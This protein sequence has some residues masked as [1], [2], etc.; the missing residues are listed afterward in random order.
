MPTTKIELLIFDCDGVL[1]VSEPVASRIFSEYLHSLDIHLTPEYVTQR[2]VGR[3]LSSCKALLQADG[4]T[5]PDTFTDD[6]RERTLAALSHDLDPISG[7]HT[8]LDGISL[9]VCVASSGRPVKIIQSL[10][11]TN[12]SQYFGDNIFSA[13]QVENPKPAPD[14]FLHAAKTMGASPGNTM[15]IEDSHVGVQAGLAAGMRVVGFTGGGHTG[16]EHGAQVSELGAHHVLDDMHDLPRLIK[17][18]N[19]P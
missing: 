1:V 19:G 7:I 11:L 5:L 15:V 16:R 17:S 18:Y 4:L 6:V 9:P 14:L 10:G 3:S 2:C 8:V 12:L 13:D